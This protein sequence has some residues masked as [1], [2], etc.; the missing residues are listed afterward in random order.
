MAGVNWPD[1][2][3][4]DIIRGNIVGSEEGKMIARYSA[5]FLVLCLAGVSVLLAPSSVAAQQP[6]SDG[7]QWVMP[8]TPDGRPDLQGN[9]SNA[10]LTPIQR[11]EGAGPTLTWDSVATM[12]GRRQGSSR[13]PTRPAIPIAKRQRLGVGGYNVLWGASTTT[14]SI[15]TGATGLPSTTVSREARSLRTPRTAAFLR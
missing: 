10:T 7:Q 5:S 12:E 8:R 13:Q 6:T 14:T 9:W 1:Q 15:S 2:I 11:P 3:E 4:G